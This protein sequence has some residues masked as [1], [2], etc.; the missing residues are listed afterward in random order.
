MSVYALLKIEERK[1]KMKKLDIKIEDR[2]CDL[3]TKNYNGPQIAKLLNKNIKTIYKILTKNNLTKSMQEAHRIF[4][5]N[6]NYFGNITT[7]RQAYWLGFISG[8]GSVTDNNIIIYLS[9]KDK[10]LLVQLNEDIKSNYIIH[11]Y[12]KY[13]KLYITSNIMVKHLNYHNIYPDKTKSFSLS[14]NIPDH[15]L[16]NYILGLNDADGCFSVDRK[17]G[18][19][20]SLVGTQKSME[21]VQDI[22]ISKCGVNKNKLQDHHTTPY[23]KYLVYSGDKQLNRITEFLYRTS[24]F[25][26]PRKF[27]VV[28]NYFSPLVK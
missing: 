26:L 27:N 22:F 8:D 24:D 1:S 19:R 9:N 23:I 3:Y 10:M 2:I 20:F 18:L 6:E 4:Q 11:E 7:P 5:C 17:R 15:L 12:G 21:Q 28:K 14:N 25:Y 13:V 16:N